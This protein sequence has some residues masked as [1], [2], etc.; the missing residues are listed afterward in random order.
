MTTALRSGDHTHIHRPLLRSCLISACAFAALIPS[1]VRAL[2]SL[3]IMV[4]GGLVVAYLS[5]RW[6]LPAVVSLDPQPD[7]WQRITLPVLNW[8]EAGMT[9]NLIAVTVVT[10]LLAP[11]LWRLHMLSDLQRMD[12]SKPATRAA[13][14]DFLERWGSLESSN[15][16]V[17]TAPSLDQALD[18]VAAA[19][20][21]LHL[22]PSRIECFLPSRSEQEHR[23]ASWNRFW[24]EHGEAFRNDFTAAC[25]ALKLR[26]SA[27]EA[28]LVRYRPRIPRPAQVW[29]IIHRPRMGC[30]A[31]PFGAGKVASGAR[32]W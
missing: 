2:H 3:G 11:G 20:V 18:Q 10:A 21:R 32:A 17:V 22:P 7:P 24:N 16:L 27:F 5:A 8:C 30:L 19:R 12:G 6:L 31:S 13:L 29:S 15:F 25:I 4:F 28:S 9:R 26:P 14:N 23:R 1:P